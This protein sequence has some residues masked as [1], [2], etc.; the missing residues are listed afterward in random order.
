M[1][2]FLW[3]L[4]MAGTIE[5]LTA[6]QVAVGVNELAARVGQDIKDL[7]DGKLNAAD[8][9]VS[10]S[11]WAA[12]ITLSFS[13]S[14]TGSVSFDGSGNKSAILTLQNSGVVAGT[15]MSTIKIP[16][17]TVNAQ[18]LI[19]GVSMND[20][21]AA[22]VG[23]T[24]IVALSGDIYSS[25][26]EHGLAATIGAVSQV[27]GL[28]YGLLSKAG[29]GINLLNDYIKTFAGVAS[30]SKADVT[31]T[32]SDE[33]TLKHVRGKRLTIECTNAA[34]PDAYIYFD[35]TPDTYENIQLQAGV[36]YIYSFYA[37]AATA[38]KK[39]R[40]VIRLADGNFAVT[41][42]H[43]LVLSETMTRYSISFIANTTG[44]AVI[45]FYPNGDGEAGNQ[46]HIS[47]LMIERVV[48]QIAGN[49]NPSEYVA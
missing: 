14:V 45:G 7:K 49:Y 1:G 39:M 22:G 28:M 5:T 18:G 27:R 25:E 31:A 43:P 4:F 3:V 13:G 34:N 6:E 29:A 35:D 17:I 47:G 41:N 11:K 10:A 2:V 20:I 23:V 37:M 30:W 8:N 15:Y 26:T 12:E 40:C 33:T 9:A 44:G 38:G 36:Q 21:R 19:T 46:F 32:V 24:G 48:S 42:P 16:S